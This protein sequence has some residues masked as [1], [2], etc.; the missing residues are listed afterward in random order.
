MGLFPL[1]A[2]AAPLAPRYSVTVEGPFITL[3]DL[4]SKLPQEV[5]KRRLAISPAPGKTQVISCLTLQT[6]LRSRRLQCRRAVHV[7][8]RAKVLTGNWLKG[9]VEKAL[10]ARHPEA[11]VTITTPLKPLSLATSPYDLSFSVR[12]SRC[13][14]FVTMKVTQDKLT[15]FY[16]FTA[17]VKVP[18]EVWVLNKGVHRGEML[19]E[20][21]LAKEERLACPGSAFYVGGL[22]QMVF[23]KNLPAGHFLSPKDVQKVPLIARRSQVTA[24]LSEKNLQIAFPALVLEEGSAG[25]V[26]QIQSL[27]NQKTFRARVLNAETVEV[28]L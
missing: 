28:I 17:E 8:R 19:T 7:A 27:Y 26:V 23:Q 22:T 20:N 2:L 16:H 5:A 10:H 9:A 1:F 18:Y 15:R 24:F 21:L 11:V 3:G 6:A 25:D 14:A 13:Q 12:E 4:F